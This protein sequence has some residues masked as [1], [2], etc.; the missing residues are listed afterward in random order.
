MGGGRGRGQRG[1]YEVTLWTDEVSKL[2]GVCEGEREV[3]P[4][5]AWGAGHRAQWYLQQEGGVCLEGAGVGGGYVVTVRGWH[6]VAAVLAALGRGG[7]HL[8]LG[9]D[10]GRV[11]PRERSL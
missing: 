3:V 2:C 10:V 5:G 1:G 4:G 7:G 6:V 9:Q 8:W 11:C